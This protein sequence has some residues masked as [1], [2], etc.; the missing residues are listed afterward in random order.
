MFPTAVLVLTLAQAAPTRQPP[1]PQTDQT[2]PVDRGS[3][4]TINNFAGEVIVHTWDKDSLHVIARHQS[5]IH[6]NI[7]PS[8]S[9]T[10]ISASSSQGPEGSVDY[11]ITAPAWMP[12]KVE[13]QFNFTTIEGTKAD[14]SANSVRGDIVIK[15]V[16]GFVTAKSIQG[17]I[18]VEGAKGKLTVSS[19]NEG[20]K[21]TDSSGEITA[22][23][24][25]GPITMTGMQAG[26]VEAT[27]TNGNITYD[28]TLADGGHYTF[29]THNGD[30]LLGIPESASAT[31]T[32]R[33]Y[34]GEFR[35]DLPLEGASREELRRGRH[36]TMTLGKG[37]ADVSLESFGG[38]IRVRKGPV[39]LPSRRRHP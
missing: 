11:D 34:S 38:T 33:T 6:V 29:T 39:Q 36:V 25:N 35:T 9:G 30:V 10:T 37:S 27:T 13:G 1:P 20:I 22:D 7:R 12:I 24:V 18:S 14:V 26:T 15:G 8:P 17:E 19:V 5:R 28:G 2:V 21:I 23:S 4:L 31:F 3:R 32:V 16:S